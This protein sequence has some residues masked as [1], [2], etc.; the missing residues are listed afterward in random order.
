MAE[1]EIDVSVIIPVY[2]GWNLIWRLF[3]ALEAQTFPRDRYEVIVVDN[4]SKCIPEDIPYFVRLLE[5]EEPG[6]YAARNIA[7]DNAR[8]ELLIFTDADCVPVRGWLQHFWNTYVGTT[9]GEIFAGAIEVKSLESDKLANSWE[10]YDS[11]L[12]LPQERFVKKRGYA[13]TANLSV[14]A[15]VF[16]EVGKFDGARFSGGDAEFCQRA[17]AAGYALIYVES[18]L[19]YHPARASWTELARKSRR[20]KGGQFRNGPIT[21]RSWFFFRHVAEPFVGAV[22]VFGERSSYTIF[23]KTRIYLV[24]IFLWLYECIEIFLLM[25][26]KKPERR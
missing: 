18:A 15:H 21:R 4:G 12:G 6:S 24:L 20:V 26:G 23:E 9:G 11:F 17:T 8:G 13:V 5:C 7:I 2:E 1:K 19:I 22:K 10:L 25:L 3:K 14:P 16:E